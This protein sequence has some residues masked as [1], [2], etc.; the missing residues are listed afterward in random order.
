MQTIAPTEC[1]GISGRFLVS[2][3]SSDIFDPPLLTSKPCMQGCVGSL[4]LSNQGVGN[5]N[6]C[7]PVVSQKSADGSP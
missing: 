1:A 6:S 3:T 2:K 7:D 5:R 4:L